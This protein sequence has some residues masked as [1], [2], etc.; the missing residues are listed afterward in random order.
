MFPLGGGGSGQITFQ[1]TTRNFKA[2]SAGAGGSGAQQLKAT[3]E[4]Y[5]LKSLADFPGTYDAAKSGF[6]IFKGKIHERLEN[7]KCVVIY[8]EGK[9]T[10]LA[11]S[12][13]VSKI[14]ITME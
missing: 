3:G 13:G 14:T 12:T 6:T 10:G 7:D 8:V 4:V 2:V 11:S 5:H 1:G 9:T